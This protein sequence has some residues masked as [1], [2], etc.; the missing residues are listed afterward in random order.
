MIHVV[1]EYRNLDKQQQV[2]LTHGDSIT[3]VGSRLK[4]SAVSAS[5][6]VAAIWNGESIFGVQ[7]HPEVSP[8]FFLLCISLLIYTNVELNGFCF[9]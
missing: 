8:P 2:L 5:Q 6:V 4:V 7:F 1:F 9:V 3:E